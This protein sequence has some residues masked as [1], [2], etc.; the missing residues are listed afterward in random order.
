[1]T[2]MG[3][4]AAW[5]ELRLGSDIRLPD[6]RSAW[7]SMRRWIAPLATQLV[8]FGSTLQAQ[9]VRGEVREAA[10]GTAVPGALVTLERLSSD[11]V[12][13]VALVG[14]LTNERGQF[15]VRAQTPGRYRL[16]AKRIGVKRTVTEP[17]E[18]GAGETKQ[19]SNSNRSCTCS[20]KS[21]WPRQPSAY[22]DKTRSD[23]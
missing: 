2:A 6:R 16:A 17:F 5:S 12:S 15:A 10:S 8:F 20:R 7:V 19:L 1:M 13:A 3:L 21:R 9:V 4:E 14:V 22:R 11:S 18:L 23:A